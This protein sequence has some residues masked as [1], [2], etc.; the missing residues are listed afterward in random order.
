VNKNPFN[1][2]KHKI[3]A[4]KN[5]FNGF[6]HNSKVNKNRFRGFNTKEIKPVP[7]SSVK[8]KQRRALSLA[9]IENQGEEEFQA[10][11]L[12]E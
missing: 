7:R 4:S 10:S 2:F 12:E 5:L 11:N 6:K 1:G 9:S 8:C 3:K